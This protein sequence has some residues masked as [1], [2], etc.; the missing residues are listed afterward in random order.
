MIFLFSMA[1]FGIKRYDSRPVLVFYF[2]SGV[3]SYLGISWMISFKML[4][5]IIII[6]L[7]KRGVRSFV[8][9][10]EDGHK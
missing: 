3:H 10:F 5:L 6:I 1:T 4:Q 2:G 7:S 8:R 9:S